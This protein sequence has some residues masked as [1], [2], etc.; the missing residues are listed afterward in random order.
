MLVIEDGN[1]DHVTLRLYDIDTKKVSKPLM[2]ENNMS[3]ASITRL[4]NAALDP[5]TM[6]SASSVLVIDRTTQPKVYERWYFWVGV[7]AVAVG[8]FA[9]YQYMTREPTA[10]RF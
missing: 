2:L 5:D 8:G 7:A 4:V 1:A 10:V 9:G 6:M 3:S